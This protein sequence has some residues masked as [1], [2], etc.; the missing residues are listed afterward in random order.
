MQIMAL[1]SSSFPL[2]SRTQKPGRG[3]QPANQLSGTSVARDPTPSYSHG[4]NSG[5]RGGR[6]SEKTLKQAR[7]RKGTN[8]VWALKKTQRS[9]N[10]KNVILFHRLGK[11]FQL[12]TDPGSMN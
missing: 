2:C 3:T 1:P 7:V 5:V 10:L 6:Q 4:M 8:A 11:G 9:V 12:E